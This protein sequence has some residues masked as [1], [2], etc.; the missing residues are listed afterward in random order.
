MTAKELDIASVIAN[1]ELKL[2]E[3]F[4]ELDEIASINHRRVL[5]A[6]RD[7]RLSEEF[8]AE[9]TGYGMDDAGREAIDKIFAAAFQAEA[10]AVRM[11]FVSGTHAIAAALFGNLK[12]GDRMV[13]LT[14]KPYDTML[15]V[16]GLPEPRPQ[17]IRA[18]GID[19]QQVDI[20]PSKI[21]ED[22][23]IRQISLHVWSPCAVA[24][25]Q[26][27]RGYSFE[28]RTLSNAEIGKMARAVKAVNPD[29]LVIVDNCYGEFVESNEPTANTVDLIAGS[30]IKNPGGGLVIGGG[31]VAGKKKYVDAALNRLTAPGIGGHLGLLFNQNRLLM[32]G[33]FSA[34]NAVVES[35]KGIML[36]AHCMMDLGL[37]V[38]PHPLERRF[39]II[40]AIEFGSEERLVNFCR[41]L[42]RFSPVN[43][44]VSPEA[45]T[46]PGYADKVVMAGGT[47][48]EGATIELS[49][50]G[51]IRPPYAGFLQGGLSYLHVKCVLEDVLRLSAVG[52]FP[53]LEL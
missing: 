31:Y 29:C 24:Y 3:H 6:M 17:T 33:L 43:S 7:N 2:K 35:V 38:R 19:Y 18:H 42:Q 37:I 14:G 52:E 49:A 45:S 51:P 25:I 46:M 44:H 47:F 5:A 22:E 20:D 4:E 9:K 1:A 10:A 8:F 27:S 39:D 53:F 34:P 32:Q 23:L 21:S 11:Q 26:K 50:D 48:I 30:M 16:I 15:K 36:F 40:Q 12:H 28:R 41:A 13:A